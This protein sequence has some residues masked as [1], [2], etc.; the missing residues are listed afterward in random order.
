VEEAMEELAGKVAV[1]A[2]ETPPPVFP[3]EIP[4]RPGSR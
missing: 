1:I 4:Q 3:T 2:G